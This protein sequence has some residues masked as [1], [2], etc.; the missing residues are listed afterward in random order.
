MN[1]TEVRSSEPSSPAAGRL[2]GGPLLMRNTAWNLLGQILP[3]VAGVFAIPVV[4]RHLGTERFGLLTLVWLVVGYF[5]LFDFGLG[6]ALTSL[7]AQK[8]GES[9]EHE[10]PSLISTAKLLMLGFSIAGGI[11][12]ALAS[13]WVVRSV[14][15][16]APA[17]QNEGIQSCYLMSLSLPFVISTT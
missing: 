10:L 11:V 7:V 16:I 13:P 12:L 3:L 9:K 2:T 4:I 14:L 1:V 8:L 15:I 6:R 5:S 17:L